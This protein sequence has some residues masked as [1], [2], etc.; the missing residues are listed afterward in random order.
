M[1][2]KPTDIVS[3][4][5]RMREALRRQMAADA[6]KAKHSINQ[7]IVR[8][9]ERSYLA[10]DM[11]LAIQIAADQAAQMSVEA[12]LRTLIERQEGKS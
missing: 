10:D 7:E 8:R 2:A 4:K 11:K 1:A 5:L 3:V 9:L 12:V 6:K